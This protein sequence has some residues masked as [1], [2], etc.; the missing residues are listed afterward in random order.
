MRPQYG[1][2]AHNFSLF[3]EG[4]P[5]I[6]NATFSIYPGRKVALIGRNGSGKS[7]LLEVIRSVANGLHLPA[8]A[9]VEGQLKVL[10]K[11]KLGY[12][13][14]EVRLFFDGTV[15][16]YLS[17]YAKDIT[18]L[19]Q[20]Y[21]EIT[22][23]LTSA[24]TP[25]EDLLETYSDIIDQMNLLDAWNFEEKKYQVLDGLGIPRQFISRHL[26]SLSGGEAT[27]VALAAL[28]LSDANVLLL[29]EPTNNLDPMGV[30]F[31]AQW[32]RE[33]PQ[34]LL[35]VSHDRRFMDIVIDE[36]L[37]IDENSKQIFLFGGNYSFYKRKKREMF[38]AQ[39]R[40]YEEQQRKRQELEEAAKRLRQQARQFEAISHD[41]FY[42]SKGAKLAKRAGVQ[43]RR[44]E[45]EL[46]QIEE[47]VPPRRPQF[48][49]PNLHL[50]EKRTLIALQGVDIKYPKM[51]DFLLKDVSLSISGQDR[52]G[53]IGQNG[54]GKTTL[55]RVCLGQLTP[56][57][58]QVFISK[59]IRVG[60]LPQ[61]P[62]IEV[63]SESI[64][65]FVSRLSGLSV[66]SAADSLGRVLFSNPHGI[67]VSDLSL[68]ELKRI[69]L[70][71]IFAS[72]PHLIALDEPTNHMDVYTIEMLEETLQIYPGALIVVS[73]D[74]AFLE[75]IGLNMLVSL[76]SGQIYKHNLKNPQ[77]ISRLFL[78][79]FGLERKK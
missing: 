9:Q 52:I 42:R 27:R 62:S 44:I 68:G 78:K 15:E 13:P 33:T 20:K 54:T 1:I 53:I 48:P 29:D 19:I 23:I 55:L 12:L 59:H 76:Q 18:D 66:E 16:D 51:I 25:S 47:P 7:T 32:I 28:L 10:P 61:T 79:V 3:A 49:T 36:I 73:H 58:G 75:N 43:L 37:E 60:Y 63:P 14:Q 74:I 50:E 57:R 2:V 35:L 69:T 39:M 26:G 56:S 17:F 72:D 11:T 77:D 30:S 41:S 31:L 71:A 21:E 65:D 22:A 38:E 70:A 34:S 24:S 8:Y 46:T 6:V 40:H 5:L 4:K 64:V 45:R 67:R